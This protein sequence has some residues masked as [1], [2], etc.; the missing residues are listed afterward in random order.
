MFILHNNRADGQDAENAE[1]MA[2]DTFDIIM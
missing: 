1:S 2:V